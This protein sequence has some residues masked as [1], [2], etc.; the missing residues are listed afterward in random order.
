MLQIGGLS[1]SGETF[2][3]VA[4][5]SDEGIEV[6]VTLTVILQSHDKTCYLSYVSV[7]HSQQR[8]Y[9]FKGSSSTCALLEI[10]FRSGS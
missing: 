3:R 8:G 2:F 10:I 9:E 7:R 6:H 5:E 4:P 1:P